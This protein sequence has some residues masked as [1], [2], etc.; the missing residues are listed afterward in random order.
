MP[1]TNYSFEKRQRD[2][3][4]KAKK[5]EKRKRKLEAKVPDAPSKP[6]DSAES[7]TQ[8]APE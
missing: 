2:L 8:A 6:G 3:A 7:G 1:R 4:K 5:D